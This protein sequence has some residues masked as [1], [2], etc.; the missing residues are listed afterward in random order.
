MTLDK[1]Q[2]VWQPGRQWWGEQ[3]SLGANPAHSLRVQRSFRAMPNPLRVEEPDNE[4][5]RKLIDDIKK[6]SPPDVSRMARVDL[7]GDGREDLVLWHVGGGRIDFKTDISVFLRGPDQKLPERPTQILHCRGIP[8]P[9]GSTFA[10]SPVVDLKGDGKYELVLLDLKPTILS[11]SGA[12]EMALS[13]GLDWL[14]TIRLFHQGAFSRSPDASVPLTGILPAEIMNEWPVFIQGDFNGDGR[15]DLFFRRSETRWNI[16]FS[17]NDAR[18]FVPEPAMTFDA[19][20]QA[21]LEIKDLRGDGLSDI[22]WHNLDQP[23][24]S[25]FMSPSHLAK[26]GKP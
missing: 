5:V 14:L 1:K 4:A 20:G 2:T 26:G 22:I 13:H 7:D 6:D 21:Y 18:W 16:F 3:W 25:I 8:I 23:A 17:T 11:Y 15:P 19:A 24:L 12:V 10:A 9:T